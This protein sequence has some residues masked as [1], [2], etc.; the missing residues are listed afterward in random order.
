LY[1]LALV[2]EFTGTT[3]VVK[4][5]VTKGIDIIKNAGAIFPYDLYPGFLIL[6]GMAIFGQFFAYA[7]LYLKTKNR[8]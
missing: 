2:N 6:V 7:V 8:S 3:Y 4:G 5:Q 1:D